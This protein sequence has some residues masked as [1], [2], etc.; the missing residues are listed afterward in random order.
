LGNNDDCSAHDVVL[1]NTE[2]ALTAAKRGDC[3]NLFPTL[4]LPHLFCVEVDDH[5]AKRWARSDYKCLDPSD[6]AISR[7][8]CREVAGLGSQEWCV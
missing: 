4:C 2:S 5:R 6:H 8:S 3:I 7:S 1:R